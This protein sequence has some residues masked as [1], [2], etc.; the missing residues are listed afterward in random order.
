VRKSIVIA[1]LLG[2][3]LP[4][5]VFAQT[6]STEAAAIDPA[7]L[8]AARP[9]IDRLW[10]LGT[11]RR[12]MGG[13]MNKMMDQLMATMFDMRAADMVGATGEDGKAVGDKS[14]GDVAAEKDPH[15]RERMKITM[16][17]M[18]GEMLPIMERMEPTIRDSLSKVYAGR[19]T[20]AQLGEINAFFATPT[21]KAFADQAMTMFM[22]PQVMKSVQG[23]A[24]ELIKAMPQIMTKVEKATAHLPPVP[25]SKD[26]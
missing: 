21:G 19:F 7:R 4:Q 9:V 8:A 20:V 3:A 13:T 6:P 10:P 17:T 11:Y 1:A 25:K 26:D 18:M 15:F 14:M 2:S 24:P 22:D 16:D 5:T 23:F 12:M